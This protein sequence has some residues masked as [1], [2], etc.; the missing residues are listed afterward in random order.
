MTVATLPLILRCRRWPKISEILFGGEPPKPQLTTALEQPV[1]GEVTFEDEVP[2]VF[3][4]R[5]RI[6]PRQIDLLAFLVGELG[7]KDEGP[8][9]EPLADD[10][11]A[12]FGGGLLKGSDIV[13]AEKSIVMLAKRDLC[14]IEFLLNEA[15]P[16]EIIG[17]LEGKEGR[18]AHDHGPEH[19]I[20]DVE[21]VVGEAALLAGQDAVI[22]VLGRELRH[23][24]PK[25]RS[26]LHALEDEEDTVSVLLH[27]FA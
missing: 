19:L 16:V 18:H 23:R 8:V 24:H 1:D 5:D 12:Q 25:R 15:V 4:L 11:G 3:E 9:V 13:N 2:A 10:D 27:H 17:R 14:A 20:A 7:P 21:V 6:E 26:L 22:G